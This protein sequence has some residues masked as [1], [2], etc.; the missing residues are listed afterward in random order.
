[1]G[2]KLFLSALRSVMW[3]P[4]DDNQM[5]K[6]FQCPL[7][8]AQMQPYFF[9]NCCTK[10][11]NFQSRGIK[12]KFPK[13]MLW[14]LNRFGHLFCKYVGS[15][16]GGQCSRLAWARSIT[17]CSSSKHGTK[18][19]LHY[20]TQGKLWQRLKE[21]NE[22]ISSEQIECHMKIPKLALIDQNAVSL[23]GIALCHANIA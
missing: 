20:P 17:L 9:L 11:L 13:S 16:T 5:G 21:G 12:F 2:E 8:K 19:P 22:Y 3:I 10:V 15:C 7:I 14:C 23:H 1:M 18:G 4:S 6:I